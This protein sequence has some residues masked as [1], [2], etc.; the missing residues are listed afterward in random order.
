MKRRNAIV[1]IPLW[2]AACSGS[3]PSDAGLDARFADAEVPDSG[4]DGGYEDAEAIDGAI[5]DAGLCV[6]PRT[7]CSGRCVDLQSDRDNCN[8]CGLVCGSGLVCS[9]GTCKKP[10]STGPY[11]TNVTVDSWY[12]V[13]DDA[14]T[15]EA[16]VSAS[17]RDQRRPRVERLD[18]HCELSAGSWVEETIRPPS[19]GSVRLEGTRQGAVALAP[20]DWG[21]YFEAP[22]GTIPWEPGD[23][24]T[25]TA[26]GAE[27]PA[28]TLT[29][30]FPVLPSSFS[31]NL[32]VFRPLP[33]Q[34]PPLAVPRAQPFMVTWDPI[35]APETIYVMF[36]QWS[37]PFADERSVDC[38]FPGS[39]GTASVSAAVLSRLDASTAIRISN[40]YLGGVTRRDST[41]GEH[42]LV[43]LL[44]NMD[45]VRV[46]LW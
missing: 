10:L 32:R 45:G 31:P 46:V 3:E 38:F 4:A 7:D 11:I 28:F 6:S 19:F 39:A 20:V 2:L 16:G 27:A 30:T 40:V 5:D 29:S 13:H 33:G 22:A 42:Q 15:H 21:Y 41:I 34:P 1:A 24:L 14:I 18:D 8:A 36:Q 37:P 12:S 43:L 9:A 26:T 44:V 23:A 17:H 25:V 35:G